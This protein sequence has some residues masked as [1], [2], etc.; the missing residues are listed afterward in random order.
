MVTKCFAIFL[1]KL[2][3]LSIDDTTTYLFLS[4]GQKNT[5]VIR[6]SPICDTSLMTPAHLDIYSSD[7]ELADQ[8]IHVIH[9]YR[10]LV[11]KAKKKKKI[12]LKYQLAN[13]ICN[14]VD[15]PRLDIC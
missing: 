4:K 12:I 5:S 1:C 7:T 13:N 3:T 14:K 15:L 2:A 11:L 9:D 6:I 10:I 8:H